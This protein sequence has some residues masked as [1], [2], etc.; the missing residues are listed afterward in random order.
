MGFDQASVVG[1]DEG[2]D[3]GHR[4]EAG[5]FQGQV[6]QRGMVKFRTGNPSPGDGEQ[7]GCGIDSDDVSASP[8]V[9]LQSEPRSAP[10]VEDVRARTDVESHGKLFVQRVEERLHEIGPV[11]RSSAQAVPGSCQPMRTSVVAVAS[12]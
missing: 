2:V 6:G 7:S 1:V 11:P 3:P 12:T 5:I 8:R 4:V 10:D 9:V